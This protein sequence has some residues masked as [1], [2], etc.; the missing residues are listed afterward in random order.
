MLFVL[1]WSTGF[2]GAK[3]GLPYAEPMT[4]LWYRYSFAALLLGGLVWWQRAPWPRQ[5]RSY[6][7]LI[8]SGLLLHGCYIGGVFIAI[9]HGTSTGIAALIMGA[10]PLLT[11]ILAGPL[12][13]ERLSPRQWCGF[14]LGFAGLAFTVQRS[15]TLGALPLFGF[16]ACI[17]GVLAMT[18]GTLYQKRYTAAVDSRVGVLVQFISA[19]IVF[20][21]GSDGFETGVVEWHPRFVFALGWLCIVMSLGAISLLWH[22]IKRGAAA[23][24]AS[25][26]YL[27]P[28]VVALE[29]YALFGETLQALQV[30]GIAIT[31]LGVALI[32]LVGGEGRAGAM[33]RNTVREI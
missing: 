20:R 31:A 24:V 32:N 21:A 10:Q 1:L 9:A 33:K 25:L 8:V 5:T 2:I 13:D 19:A 17:I 16:V 15:A 12:L 30:L 26:F 4:F 7:H 23:R 29:G 3:F 22:L 28:P 6:G 18:L 14:A 27:V 11:A